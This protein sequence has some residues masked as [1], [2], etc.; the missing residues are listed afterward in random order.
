MFLWRSL[1]RINEMAYSPEK[2]EAKVW[3]WNGVQGVEIVQ[4]IPCRQL[5]RK[6]RRTLPGRENT[7]FSV[8]R[9]RKVYNF[10]SVTSCGA[11]R[12]NDASGVRAEPPEGVEKTQPRVPNVWENG[13]GTGTG[14]QPPRRVS[15]RDTARREQGGV[16]ERERRQRQRGERA[17]PEA[18]STIADAFRRGVAPRRGFGS[19][20][21]RVPIL[22]DPRP[23]R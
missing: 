14:G 19:G 1:R 18:S 10:Q 15:G 7:R 17:K 11:P 21:R 8:L 13:S 4:V 5:R 9:R 22:W 20:R 3:F 6:I 2:Q 23:A 12:I 16:R